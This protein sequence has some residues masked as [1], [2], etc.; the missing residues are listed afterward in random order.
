MNKLRFSMKILEFGMHASKNITMN[1]DLIGHILLF[2][3][4]FHPAA[5]NIDLSL[6]HRGHCLLAK[7]MGRLLH[8]I[9]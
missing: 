8:K 1:N 2:A 6:A 3:C 5:E 4:Y 7:L 9:M